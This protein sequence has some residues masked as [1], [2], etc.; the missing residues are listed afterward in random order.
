MKAE[1]TDYFSAKITK[2]NNCLP[3]TRL[4]CHISEQTNKFR[5]TFFFFFLPYCI[6]HIF[7]NTY[8]DK[9][10]SLEKFESVVFLLFMYFCEARRIQSLS[11]Q[12]FYFG[13]DSSQNWKRSEVD[14][15]L[16]FGSKDTM[17]RMVIVI[18]DWQAEL[19]T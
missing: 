7:V 19:R 15:T 5:K 12:R 1:T 8:I 3:Y 13:V 17:W 10:N 16:P 2:S 11:Q 6:L 18:S 14:R 9:K 4:I